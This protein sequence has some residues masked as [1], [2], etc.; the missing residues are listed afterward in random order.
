MTGYDDRGWV[1]F[2]PDPRTLA[3]AKAA[4]TAAREAIAAPENAHWLR[5][6][7][8]WFA[9]VNVLPNAPDGS[10]RGIPLAGPALDFLADHEA[11]PAAWD[12]AQISVVYPGYPQPGPGETPANATYRRKRDAAH[13]DGLLPVGP[14]RRR[15]L[16]ETHG[17]VLGIP[18][19]QASAEASPMVV[20]EGSHQ[21]IGAALAQVLRPH[22]PDTWTEIDVT[23][24]YHAARRR[25]F[26]T[27]RRR[28]VHVPVGGAYVV[29]RHALHGVAP[30]AEGA[31][32]DPEGRII[33]YFR[34]EIAP[35]RWL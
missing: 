16:G 20:W 4:L 11:M 10:L 13:V 28:I 29:H 22:P 6:G 5:H 24:A 12:R 34:P 17:F 25:C 19:T 32:A 23:D 21:I 27:C 2:A 31:S 8:T 14:D 30:W 33:A 26:D 18:L 9:G 1:A 3:W 35:E 7:G 15:V